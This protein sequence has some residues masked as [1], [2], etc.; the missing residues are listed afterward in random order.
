[1]SNKKR[2]KI[3]INAMDGAIIISPDRIK[4]LSPDPECYQV[5]DSA[6][7]KNIQDNINNSGMDM[8][9]PAKFEDIALITSYILHAL[10]RLDWK[11]DF[12]DGASEIQKMLNDEKENEKRSHLKIIK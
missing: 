8:E 4:A 5:Q 7:A 12:L 9:T 10:N 3:L 1:M 2:H 11:Q 6:I